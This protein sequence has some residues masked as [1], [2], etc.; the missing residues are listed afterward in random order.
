MK[1][2]LDQIFP[3]LNRKP[4][5]FVGYGNPG[6]ARAIEQLRLVTVE[7]EMAPL[8]HAGHI[9]PVVMI[10]AMKLSNRSTLRSSPPLTN[11]WIPRPLT[12]CGGRRRWRWRDLQ[13]SLAE[14]IPASGRPAR[15]TV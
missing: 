15:G 14:A 4:V 13:A 6:G 2:A 3:E 5:T 8:R 7:L 1:N 10:E 12:W 11:V 9:L